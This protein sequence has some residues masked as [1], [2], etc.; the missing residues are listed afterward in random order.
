MFGW[1]AVLGLLDLDA[2]QTAGRRCHDEDLES[3]IDDALAA[4]STLGWTP[5]LVSTVVGNVTDCQELHLNGLRGPRIATPF[6]AALGV[7][8]GAPCVGLRLLDFEGSRLEDSGAVAI[9]PVVASCRS[10]EAI[11]APANRIGDVGAHAIAAA[12]H[13]PPHPACQILDLQANA[14][15][16]FGAGEISRLLRLP[17]PP[18]APVPLNELRLHQ[19][20]IGPHGFALLADAMRDNMILHT[21]FL[22]SNP[23]GD[24]GAAALA[25][26]LTARK[27][28]R[29][30]VLRR[31]YL[32]ATNMTDIGAQALLTA[33]EAT[34]AP[35]LDTLVLDGN[36]GLSST[37]RARLEA[38][39]A[40]NAA[41][42]GLGV[43]LGGD[44][45][46]AHQTPVGATGI[47][48]R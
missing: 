42:V 45:S 35:P 43:G 1:V 4:N 22:S 30:S 40:R 6:A 12:L 16:D 23:G 13:E 17:A 2:Q 41:A 20:Q 24:V 36:L 25:H 5:E 8:D 18:I 48:L 47:F 29:D 34:N 7:N 39:V 32:A 31:L 28:G 3:A 14:I 15:G 26:G 38:I 44:G 27:A 21:L 46:A 9:A 33:L 37:M 19:N 10:L 11:H